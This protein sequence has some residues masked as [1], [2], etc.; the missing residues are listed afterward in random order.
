MNVRRYYN[1]FSLVLYAL[2]L[3]FLA[4]EPFV[5]RTG[6]GPRIRQAFSSGHG[7]V[8]AVFLPLGLYFALLLVGI[9]LAW[10][11]RLVTGKH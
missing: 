5:G 10:L 7:W 2:W 8:L 9:T 11:F 1:R 6:Q 4:A 3:V